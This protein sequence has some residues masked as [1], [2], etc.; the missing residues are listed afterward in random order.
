MTFGFAFSSTFV[1]G[2]RNTTRQD[3]SGRTFAS[4]S[5]ISIFTLTEPFWRSAVGTIWRRRA[6]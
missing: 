5:G 1:S 2:F 4:L 3:I 6:L